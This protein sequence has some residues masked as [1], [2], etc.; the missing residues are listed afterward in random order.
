MSFGAVQL[1]NAGRQLLTQAIAG[2]SLHFTKMQMGSGGLTT[3]AVPDLTA[4]I[5]PVKEVPL[6]TITQNGEYVSIQGTFSNQGL[7][8]GFWW[9]EIGLFAKAGKSSAEEILFSYANAYELAEYITAAGSEIMEKTLRMPVFVS[10]VKEITATINSSL[11][12]VSMEDFLAH[13][14]NEALHIPTGGK[15][16]QVLAKSEDGTEWADIVQAP[17]FD[18]LLAW[19]GC[20]RVTPPKEGGT[21][22]ESIV[23]TEGNSLRAKRVT[24]Q[25]GDGDYTETYSFYAEDGVTVRERYVVH[26]MKDGTAETW[27]ETVTKEGDTNG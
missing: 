24:V 9:R 19:P 17:D 20:T 21:W 14:E 11:I 8:A 3:Q 16:G 6:S 25:N 12:Y 4:L 15:E 23:T 5:L 27:R 1:T 18:N 22:T 13:A 2:G 7:E 10:S 26:T